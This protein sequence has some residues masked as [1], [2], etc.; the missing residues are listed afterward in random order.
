M[1]FNLFVSVWCCL[2]WSALLMGLIDYLKEKKKNKALDKNVTEIGIS[3][4]THAEM[5]ADRKA[6]TGDSQVTSTWVP[7]SE[8]R[9]EVSP[10]LYK[11]CYQISILVLVSCFGLG[12]LASK[13][14]S[15]ARKNVHLSRLCER[16]GP[17]TRGYHSGVWSNHADLKHLVG[18][19]ITKV[20]RIKNAK[21]LCGHD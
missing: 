9:G 2:I 20:E 19:D 21:K 6:K 13:G 17:L 4:F 8:K 7:V 1:I 15:I 12:T 10:W 5:H 11:Y 18:K 16:T 3:A 14:Y